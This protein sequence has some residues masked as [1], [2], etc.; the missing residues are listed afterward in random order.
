MENYLIFAMGFSPF[1]SDG[2]YESFFFKANSQRFLSH[3]R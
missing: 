2:H 1:S 3:Q